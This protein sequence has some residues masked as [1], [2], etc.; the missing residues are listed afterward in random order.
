MHIRP[1][2]L[3][4]VIVA[5]AILLTGS[6][7]LSSPS[8]TYVGPHTGAGNLPAGCIVDRDPLNP[9]NEC[10]HMLV[11]LN[12]LDTPK[13]DVD[14][15]VPVS[16]AAERDLRIAEQAVDM[17]NSG[18][19][20]LSGE[21]DLDWLSAGLDMNIR[22]H[23]L[24]VNPNGTL[25]NPINLVDPEIVVVLS[26]PAGG[27][28]IGIDPSNFISQVGVTDGEGVPCVGIAN[29]FSMAGWKKRGME[30]HGNEQGGT[31]VEDC[32]GVGGNVCFAVNGAI[33]P[34]P[35]QSDFFGA[36][37]LVAHEFGHCLTVGHVGDGA[38]GPWGPTPTNDIMA[39]STDPPGISKCVSTL[40]VE[41]FAIRMSNYLDVNGD[42]KIDTKD[43]LIPNDETGDGLNSFQVQHPQDHLYASS[44]G[45]PADCPQPDN[46]LIP[47]S[48]ADFT[49]KPKATT[50]P[51]LSSRPAVRGGRLTVRGSATNVSIKRL[52]TT[53]AAS[54]TDPSGDSIAGVT[55]LTGL[56]VRT[57][58]DWVEATMSVGQVWPVAQAGSVTAY[59]LLVNGR[60]LDS[61]I[62]TGQT[63]GAPKVMDNGTGY[64][65]PEDT[66]TWDYATNTVRFKVS[67]AYLADQQV[68]APYT[69]H[70]ITGLHA[71]SND[72]LA[73]TDS[74][75]DV[76]GLALAAPKAGRDVR[77]APRAAKVTTRTLT[78]GAGSFVPSDSTLG[79]GLVST[80]DN[81]DYLT[82][83]VAQQATAKVTL[84][85]DDP[86]AILGLKVDGG[87]S[88]EVVEGDGSVTVTVPWARR[89]LSVTVDPQYVYGPTSY[90]LKT[91][92]TTVV[93]DRDED[94]VPDV[95]DGCKAKPGPST[96]GGCPDTDGDGLF[97]TNDRCPK[98]ASTSASGCPTK[99][100]E[101]VVL[102]VDG[103]RV[104]SQTV[105][106]AHG[107]D[108]FVLRAPERLTR[109]AHRV[110]VVWMRDGKV[111]R[112]QTRTLR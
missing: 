1:R 20:Y 46:S 89:A 105:V 101:R 28:G 47:G 3:L 79:V 41:G 14:I 76:Q 21:M 37:D 49:P 55:D 73:T 53:Y 102:L 43:H 10:Y 44:T 68:F 33:D 63:G 39:Y 103:R 54:A 109:G 94:G 67:R 22:T 82:I 72:W 71:R 16:P 6:P 110:A 95:A 74:V 93:A 15:L 88:Q 69:V 32:G 9:D 108:A 4:L 38:D 57:S 59:S 75:P 84:T 30:I 18:I 64:Y 11:G 31:Y 106:T 86:T 26:N 52:P 90:T 77:D 7:A 107:S 85:W 99:A 87:S 17:W 83:P 35:G 66:A 91:T 92:L 80:V 56:K 78:A 34:L 111:L 104:A 27:I 36:F 23:E 29:P 58:K 8:S 51:R 81:K 2:P 40:D 13:V 112:K 45:D 65:L 98:A 25:A 50:K 48:Y 19:H 42:G 62:G 61:F 100:D 70:G 96:S 97:D 5:I 60:R 12:A 24:V